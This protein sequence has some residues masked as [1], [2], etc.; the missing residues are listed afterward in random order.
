MFRRGTPPCAVEQ[1]PGTSESETS[2]RDV[3][4]RAKHESKSRPFFFHES[5]PLSF[6]TEVLEMLPKDL[7]AIAMRTIGIALI[8]GARRSLS[9]E[10]WDLSAQ[11]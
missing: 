10:H 11:S 8:A 2:E 1:V 5:R 9:W 7:M 4:R 3:E 6:P